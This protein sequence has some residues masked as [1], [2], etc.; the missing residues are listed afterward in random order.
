MKESACAK[1]FET[2]L[3][4]KASFILA[5]ILAIALRCRPA[6]SLIGSRYTERT[7]ELDAA[8]LISEA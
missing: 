7:I 6:A 8:C 1:K 2:R 3:L 5:F 4:F